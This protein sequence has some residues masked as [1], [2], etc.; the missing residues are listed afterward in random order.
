MDPGV[1]AQ[2]ATVVTSGRFP[3]SDPPVSP[4]LQWNRSGS[5][6]QVVSGPDVQLTVSPTRELLSEVHVW[7]FSRLLWRPLSP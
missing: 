1:R 3:P 6:S 7:P 2:S 4:S 5:S